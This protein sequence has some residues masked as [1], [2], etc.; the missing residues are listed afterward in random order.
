[1]S[2]FKNKNMM[3][4]LGAAA[5]IAVGYLLFGGESDVADLTVGDTASPAE[6]LFIDLAGQL[7][8][9]AFNGGVLSD[10]R[11]FSLVDIRTAI[12]PETSGRPDP[13][14]PLGR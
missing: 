14:A 6:L 4:G 12:I 7:D 1:M 2:L 5:L 13:F 11:F 3:L 8:P 9:I 10:S